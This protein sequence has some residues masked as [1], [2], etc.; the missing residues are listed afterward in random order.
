MLSHVHFDIWQYL[1]MAT[2]GSKL[3]G[4][5]GKWVIYNKTV[6]FI[7]VTTAVVPLALASGL[8]IIVYLH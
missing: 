5:Q 3:M 1:P 8:C 7:P 2:I 4:F 6:M